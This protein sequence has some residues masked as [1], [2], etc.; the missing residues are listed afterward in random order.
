MSLETA[1]EK[2][3]ELVL[4][5]ECKRRG[6]LCIKNNPITN[7]GIPDRLLVFPSGKVVWCELK[8]P[9]GGMLM[10]AQIEY[11]KKLYDLDQVVENLNNRLLVPSMLDS[12]E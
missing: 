10:P 4:L 1:K 11:Q 5:Q 3:T 12:Y 2:A 7:R 6:I 8:R 9:I